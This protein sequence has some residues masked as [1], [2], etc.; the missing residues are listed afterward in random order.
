[1]DSFDPSTW[2]PSG[3]LSAPLNNDDDGD[4]DDDNKPGLRSCLAS[5]PSLFWSSSSNEP[6]IIPNLLSYLYHFLKHFLLHSESS[7]G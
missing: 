2:N 1:M 5:P 7:L 6:Q 4:S 3:L